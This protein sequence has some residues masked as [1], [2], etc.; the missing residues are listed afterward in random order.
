MKLPRIRQVRTTALATPTAPPLARRV[1][2]LNLPIGP[3][4]VLPV[5][6]AGRAGRL[7]PAGQFRARRVAQSAQ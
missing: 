3:T 5:I 4:E 7:T 1:P 6:R 2:G